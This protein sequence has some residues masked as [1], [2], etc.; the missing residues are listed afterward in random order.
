MEK[1][2]DNFDWFDEYYT[3]RINENEEQ[4]KTAFQDTLYDIGYPQEFCITKYVAGEIN[5]DDEPKI[6]MDEKSSKDK[7][8]KSKKQCI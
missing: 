2:F 6:S 1:A 7:V 4:I 3:N 8:K 5:L